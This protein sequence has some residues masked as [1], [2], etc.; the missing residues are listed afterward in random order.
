MPHSETHGSTPTRGSPWL[1]AAC[2][3]LH[4]LLAPRHPPNALLT[5]DQ[6]RT[7]ENTRAAKMLLTFPGHTL[8]HTAGA[9]APDTQ[10]PVSQSTPHF[11]LSNT[12][13][14]KPTA[15][16]A[17]RTGRGTHRRTPHPS[18]SR[19]HVSTTCGMR[20][21]VGQGRLELPTSR[22]SSAR[23]DQLSYW[24]SWWRRSDSNRRPAACKAAALPAELRP[25]SAPGLPPENTRL[26]APH[27]RNMP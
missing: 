6:P 1:F 14:V 27:A 18:P 22:L 9:P 19:H 16:N 12:A 23:S 25:R 11:T 17:P 4:R 8:P 7:R 5:L 24:P 20:A 10:E 3:V 2:H 13:A 15:K 26:I 21:L